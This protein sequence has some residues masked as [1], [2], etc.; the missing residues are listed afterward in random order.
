[1]KKEKENVM[2]QGKCEECGTEIE[3]ESGTVENEIIDCDDCGAELEVISLD[4]VKLEPAPE[5]QE[6]WGE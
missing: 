6:D 2:S 5:E 3:L 4:P 1:L